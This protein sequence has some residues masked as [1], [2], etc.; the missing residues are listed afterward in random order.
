M[1]PV[2]QIVDEIKATKSKQILFADSN[3]AGNKGKAVRLMESLIPLKISWS[4]LWTANLLLDLD[5]MQLAKR[6]GLQHVNIGVESIKQETLNAMKKRTT[7][8]DRLAE[9]IKVLHK[10]GISFSFN[11]IFGWDTDHKQDFRATLDFLQE[12]KVHV[13]FFYSFAP[14]KGTPIYDRYLGEGRILDPENMNRWPGISAKIRPKNL[15]AEE[16]EMGI[17]MMYRQFYS[18]SSMRQRLPLPVSKS[19]FN[20]WFMN[21]SQRKMASG[22][23]LSFEN[24]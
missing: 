8:A 20:S 3:F 23:T 18:F 4:T 22:K 2:E 7:K 6:S 1:R 17:K 21:L 14:H 13:A 5:F 11:L 15:S 24:F 10:L 16:L 12:N 19:S 9:G